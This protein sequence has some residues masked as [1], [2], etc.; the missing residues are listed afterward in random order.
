LLI[1]WA[2]FVI[3]GQIDAV[4]FFFGHVY[5][6]V[7]LTF[8]CF[9]AALFIRHMVFRRSIDYYCTEPPGAD[10]YFIRDWNG[11]DPSLKVVLALTTFLVLFLGAC[12]IAA[13]V[14]K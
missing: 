2:L 6:I 8:S 14:A 4:V 11:L 1:I 5:Y 10:S 13:S 12:W 9:I 3:G 7:E